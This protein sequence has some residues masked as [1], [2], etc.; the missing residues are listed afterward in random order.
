ML[1]S[2]SH[3]LDENEPTAHEIFR[4]TAPQLFRALSR[5]GLTAELRPLLAR[6]Y[7]VGADDPAMKLCAAIGWFALGET[8]R[9]NRILND[10]RERLFVVGFSNERD[11]TRIA[12]A[13]A[14]ALAHA[15]PRLALGRLEELFQRLGP[16]AAGGATSAYFAPWCAMLD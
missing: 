16:I 13:Y 6:W 5:C 2:L 7:R 15:P 4:L 8:E 12:L 3:A 10:A 9:G 1:A 14:H 11:R